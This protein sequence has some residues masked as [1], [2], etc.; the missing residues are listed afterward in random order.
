MIYVCENNMYNEYTHYSETTAGEVL[1][2]PAA[3]GIPGG[4]RGR[5]GCSR[6]V[7]QAASRLV[8]RA[9]SGEGP[10]FCC[11]TPIATAAITSATSIANTTAPSRKSSVVDRARS[12]R[13]SGEMADR[14]EDWPTH[15]ALDRIQTEVQNGDECSRGL[16]HRRSLSSRESS[17]RGRVCLKQRLRRMFV[18]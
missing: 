18:N 8:E 16:R 7:C 5:A 3:F 17:G 13:A 10:R 9:R 1:A 4:E 14:A 11:A 12:H 2:R 15:A 6:R